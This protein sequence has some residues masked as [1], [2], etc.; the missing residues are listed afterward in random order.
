MYLYGDTAKE[1]KVSTSQLS[2]A[3]VENW[4]NSQMPVDFDSVLWM[5]IDGCD[6]EWIGLLMEKSSHE[7]DDGKVGGPSRGHLPPEI[8]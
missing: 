8:V 2:Y 5:V 7:V 4:P 1:K 6:E 3:L